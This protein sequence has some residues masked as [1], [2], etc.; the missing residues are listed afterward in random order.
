ME[1][2]ALVAIID[3]YYLDGLGEKV[4]W[5]VKDKILTVKTFSPNK[6]MV[7]VITA[8][9]ELEDVVFVIYDT[10]R[11]I[12]LIN[13][14]DLFLTIEPKI[15]EGTATRLLIADNQ[16]NLE[17][18]LANLQLAPQTDFSFEDF[19]EHYSFVVDEEFIDRFL[20]ARKALGTAVC[21]IKLYAN[22]AGE[23]KIE[24]SLGE[25]EGHTNKINFETNTNSVPHEIVTTSLA[26]NAD[27]IKSIFDANYKANG[28][29]VVNNE[30]AL[31]LDFES[32]NGQKS[33]YIILA[34]T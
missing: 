18:A 11:F 21:N 33:S 8:P 14:C 15:E 24:F 7:G 31:K 17:Y 30:G 1:K 19:E 22:E 12:K 34:N 16:Y 10:S 25:T 6:D 23:P 32:E 26:F 4:K 29:G 9:L 20:K 3:K 27:F 5:T 2:K 28:K 13:I